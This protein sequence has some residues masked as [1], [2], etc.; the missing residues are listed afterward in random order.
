VRVTA[1]FR[2]LVA[3]AAAYAVAQS[4]SWLQPVLLN[5][6]LNLKGTTNASAG[7]V[8]SVEMAALALSA[9][10]CSRLKP[11]I[12][13][14]SVALT[15]AILSA[16]A[17][18]GSLATS[19]YASLA[20]ARFLCGLGEGATLM[21]AT[22]ALAR[23]ANPDRAYG[24]INVVNILLGTALVYAAPIVGHLARGHMTFPTLIVYVAVLSPALLLMPRSE[25][26]QSYSTSLNSHAVRSLPRSLVVIGVAC[27]LCGITSAAMWAFYFV[28]G[29]RTGLNANS[30]NDA[31]ALAA[32]LS[33]AGSAA[34]GILGNRFGR[35]LPI[36]CGLI[37]LAVAIF[38]VTHTRSPLVFRLAMGLHLA[39]IYFLL[40]Y[41]YG[42]AAAED[43]AG[44]GT[45]VISAAFFTTLAIGPYFGGFLFELAGYESMGW[46]ALIANAAAVFLVM[47]ANKIS[48]VAR[49]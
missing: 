35:V 28:I 7:F 27:L 44:R 10:A 37:A 34:A 39:G 36:A 21:S 46:L 20:G 47:Y 29:E 49:D 15:G 17:N 42:F 13:F 32:F 48:S 4:T 5:E 33:L 1:D 24:A 6:I 40:P 3:A 14:F 43:R 26:L 30:I 9:A 16:L 31:I 2:V 11:G 41:L 18:V 19:D 23:F 38:S 25:R 22:T 8:L 12:S 45:G